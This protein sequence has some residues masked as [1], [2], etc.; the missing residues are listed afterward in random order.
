MWILSVVLLI[1]GLFC[2]FLFASVQSARRISDL[3]VQ[4]ECWRRKYELLHLRERSR[5]PRPMRVN[6]WL[7]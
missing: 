5:Q 3:W 1:V 2:G 4:S 7:N 6:S